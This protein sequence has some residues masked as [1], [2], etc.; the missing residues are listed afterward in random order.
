MFF[1]HRIGATILSHHVDDFTLVSAFFLFSIGCVNILLG[2]IFRESAKTK[3]SIWYWRDEAKGFASSARDMQVKFVGPT[4]TFANNTF[5]GRGSMEKRTMP[6]E[7]GGRSSPSDLSSSDEKYGYGVGLGFG[8]QAEHAAGL[9]G[10]LISKPLETLP[11]YTPSP[12]PPSTRSVRPP[13]I[14][15]TQ[16]PPPTAMVG[17]VPSPQRSR[18]SEPSRYSQP[19]PSRYSH[20]SDEPE[21][22]PMPVPTFKSSGTAL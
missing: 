1:C 20:A 14:I 9:K 11:R 10:F 19:S 6:G 8:R 7:F 21:V 4:S 17:S 12:H 16:S 3:R 13:S 15:V 22:P 2:L 18:F 5:L